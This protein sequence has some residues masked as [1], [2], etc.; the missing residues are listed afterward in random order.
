MA[1]RTRARTHTHTHTHTH[2]WR[3]LTSIDLLL[4]I[5]SEHGAACS[6]R[7]P[8]LP[9]A[10]RHA[11]PL[12][13]HAE[14]RMHVRSHPQLG[15]ALSLLSSLPH[16][17]PLALSPM[18][19]RFLSPAPIL[20]P[21]LAPFPLFPVFIET[22][23]PDRAAC[24]SNWTQSAYPALSPCVSPLAPCGPYSLLCI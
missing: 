12:A 9:D 15:Y 4:M 8:E 22:L 17:A 23:K 19:A 21:S 20:A 1:T 2:Y 3:Q 6:A 14:R 10:A 16:S 5:C 24:L 7:E 18:R 11:H 13:H